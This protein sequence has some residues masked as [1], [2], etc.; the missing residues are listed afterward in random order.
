MKMKDYYFT[1]F[2]RYL[3]IYLIAHIIIS[4]MIASQLSYVSFY[5]PF[6]LFILFDVFLIIQNFFIQIFIS[7]AKFG[8]FILLTFFVSQF[9][10]WYVIVDDPFPT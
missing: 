2:C 7:K 10:I 8:V 6:L 1:W 4:G 9:V 3:I 5:I